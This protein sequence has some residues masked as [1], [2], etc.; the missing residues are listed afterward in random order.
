VF[1]IAEDL[2]DSSK[3]VPNKTVHT[4]TGLFQARIL[5]LIKKKKAL[6]TKA[7]ETKSEIKFLTK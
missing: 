4:W 6:N 2:A 1:K 5:T 7:K 3:D